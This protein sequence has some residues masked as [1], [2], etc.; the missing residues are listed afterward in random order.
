MGE[1]SPSTLKSEGAQASPA[2]LY[3][4]PCI[5]NITIVIRYY[6][7]RVMCIKNLFYNNYYH[8]R[9]FIFKTIFL[10]MHLIKF[11]VYPPILINTLNQLFRLA[12]QMIVSPLGLEVVQGSVTGEG[13]LG[14]PCGTFDGSTSLSSDMSLLD[15]VHLYVSVAIPVI[16]IYNREPI[17]L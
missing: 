7:V 6:I 2:P 5:V 15:S 17:G 13:G 14:M 1:F 9:K 8:F 4:R 3:L 16:C 10:I 11:P 12:Y